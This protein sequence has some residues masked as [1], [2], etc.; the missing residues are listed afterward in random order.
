MTPAAENSNMPDNTQPARKIGT[1]KAFSWK[2]FF[3]QWEWVLVGLLIVVFIIDSLISPYFLSARTFIN[4]PMTFLDKSFIVFPM[5]FVILLGKIDI[6][7]ASTTALSAV[8]M[9][10]SY[11]AGLP[12]PLAII[13]CLLVGFLCGALNGFL[14]IK[15][16]E[17]SA[18][19]VTLSTMII[20]RGIA[21]IILGD[22]ASGGF[23]EWFSFF[24][25][26]TVAGIPFITIIFVITAVVFGILLHKTILGRI[27]YGL[28]FN[29]K[30]CTY[31]GIKADKAV[32]IVFALAGLMSAI[33][34]IFLTSRM[35]STRPNVAVGYEL[36]I[37]TMVALGGVSTSGG[38][39]RIGGPILAVFIIGFLSY[40]MG[41]ANIQAPVV[42]VA[43]GALLIFSVLMLKFRK[44]KTVN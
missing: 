3:L 19:I 39:G 37:I 24:G 23:P 34:A 20:Y 31:S 44:N 16:K 36:E 25:W 26:G 42:L 29:E 27:I 1:S 4:T 9:G 6:S 11:N 35:G 14:M 21:Y 22:Q 33:T 40:G 43:I 7:V 17:M 8:I 28:G 5:I 18:V 32:F 15:F 13:L 30:T 41:L 10:I 2:Q 12:M 38:I